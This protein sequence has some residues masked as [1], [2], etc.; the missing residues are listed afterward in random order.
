MA[1]SS[2][3]STS[4]SCSRKYSTRASIPAWRTTSLCTLFMSVHV[5]QLVPLQ[6]QHSQFSAWPGTHTLHADAH[7]FHRPFLRKSGTHNRTIR[8][9]CTS[10]DC[11]RQVSQS[12]SNIVDIC[13]STPSPYY[14]RR[15]NGNVYAR[16][17]L[18]TPRCCRVPRT[19][20]TSVPACCIYCNYYML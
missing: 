19:T 5:A 13:E 3:E 7:R 2:G 15:T 6:R 12:P 16:L 10:S 1:C 20:A 9:T 18:A 8:H 17:P 4:L 14:F 11:S